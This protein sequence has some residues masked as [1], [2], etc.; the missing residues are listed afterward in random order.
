MKECEENELEDFPRRMREWLFNVMEEMAERSELKPKFSKMHEEAKF[1]LTQQWRNAAIWKW[2]ELDGKPKDNYVSRHEL[3]PVKA[4]LKALE[5]CI[6]DFLDNC[7][8]DTDNE[9][10]FQE[11]AKC[12]EIDESE[13]EANCE[14]L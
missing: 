11:W 1:D 12:L 7:D 5:H 4:P 13:F 6:G 8:V 9:I 14:D 10:T 3:F 2:C